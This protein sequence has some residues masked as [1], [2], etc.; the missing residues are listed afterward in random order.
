MT[1]DRSQFYG[2]DPE[3]SRDASRNMDTGAQD[4]KS[5]VGNVSAMLDSVL[6]IGPAA[7][8][9]KQDWDGSL[10]PELEAATDSLSEN[11]AELRRRADLQ[12]EVSS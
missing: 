12:D 9:F 5:M 11:A 7:A 3:Y 2:I 6:W 10:R 1:Y 8:K 4:L